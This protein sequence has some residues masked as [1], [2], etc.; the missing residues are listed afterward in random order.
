[1]QTA[2]AAY[3]TTIDGGGYPYTRAMFNLRNKDM[4]PLLADIFESH[5][6]DLMVYFTTNTSSVKL[7]QLRVNPKVSVYYCNPLEFHG[8]MLSGDIQIV[9][10]PHLKRTL[11]QPG[12]ERYYPQGPD[13]PDHTV[14]RL[15]P[16]LA[17][18]WHA[19]ERF[20]FSL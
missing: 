3:L 6:R 8:V 7:S 5:D 11:W 20:E 13:D 15:L 9:S 12:W 4:F 1:M 14:L 10:D 16:R 18:G 17:R 19:S 2:P